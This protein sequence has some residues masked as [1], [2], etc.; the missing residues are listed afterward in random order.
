M[1]K[2]PKT[3]EAKPVDP[4]LNITNEMAN[5]DRRNIRFYQDL[6]AEQKK[7]MGGMYPILRWMSILYN[8]DPA[9]CE[10]YVT[11]VNDFAN[12]GFWDLGKHPDLQ[13]KLIS[14][15]GV[16]MPV[17]HSWI[18]AS[19]KTNSNKLDNLILEENPSLSNQELYIVKSK[20]TKDALGQH[21]RDLG[22]LD[23]EIKPYYEELKKF[24]EKNGL[25]D[26]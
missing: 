20:L 23:N 22:W 10:F 6:T 14:R 13:W 12:V 3:K 21:C 16:G 4:V 15:A 17:K 11:T 2:T 26:S 24:K 9:L 8:N 5:A 25:E 19:S 1:A 18:S 7:K